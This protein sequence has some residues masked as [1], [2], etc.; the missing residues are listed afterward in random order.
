MAQATQSTD[1]EMLARVMSLIMLSSVGLQPLSSMLAGLL[2]DVSA[3]LMF[4][5]AGLL[6][7]AT[8][9]YLLSQEEWRAVQ[10]DT[11]RLSA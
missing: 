1:P 10:S 3:P 6:I 8:A 5:G 4:G 9:L 11:A 2:V 7:L